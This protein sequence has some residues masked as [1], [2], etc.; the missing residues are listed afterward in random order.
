MAQQPSSR[1]PENLQQQEALVQQG[2]LEEAKAATLEELRQSPSVEGYNLLGIIESEERS[3]SNA[4][5]A[6]HKALKLP[7][8]T[9]P[10][11]TITWATSTWPRRSF[12]LAEKEF[13]TV[14]RLDPG[15]GTRTTI[16]ACS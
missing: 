5:D 3:Y 14:L 16:S 1:A 4:V 8:P 2:R 11:P 9:P 7:P 15:I 10:R 13:R 12:D 6:F